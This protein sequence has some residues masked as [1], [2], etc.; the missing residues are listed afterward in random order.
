MRRNLHPAS[1][2]NFVK[3][4]IGWKSQKLF[5]MLGSYQLVQQAGRGFEVWQVAKCGKLVGQP[6]LEQVEAEAAA[7]VEW[8]LEPQ[9][10]P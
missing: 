10:L 3:Q 9:P 7:V 5:E 8:R 2:V 1:G 6:I 4:L